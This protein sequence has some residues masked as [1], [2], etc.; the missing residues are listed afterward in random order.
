VTFKINTQHTHRP[1]TPDQWD[2]Y[3]TATAS[4]RGKRACA[5]DLRGDPK[6][7]TAGIP[8]GSLPLSIIVACTTT[9]RRLNGGVTQQDTTANPPKQQTLLMGMFLDH[10][11]PAGC[12]V[13]QDLLLDSQVSCCIATDNEYTRVHAPGIPSIKR[14]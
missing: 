11:T 2:A 5:F 4:S 12:V 10:S 1:P 8:L 6:D 9:G 7:T 14:V 3:Y 13:L